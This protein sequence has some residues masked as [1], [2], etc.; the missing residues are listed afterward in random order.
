MSV[1]PDAWEEAQDPATGRT[2]FWRRSTGETTWQR[3]D[4]TPM[5]KGDMQLPTMGH[6]GAPPLSRVAHAVPVQQ[7]M[8]ARPVTFPTGIPAMG[9]P[10]LRPHD[11]NSDICDCCENSFCDGCF[12]CCCS[13][14]RAGDVAILMS[15]TDTPC[16]CTGNYPGACFAHAALGQLTSLTVAAGTALAFRSM[17]IFAPQVFFPV[18]VTCPMR[19][20]VRAKYAIPGWCCSDFWMSYFCEP[21]VLHQVWR[22]LRERDIVQRYSASSNIPMPAG[23]WVQ[24]VRDVV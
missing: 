13:P 12:S 15:R 23:Q 1:S 9:R 10:E 7:V 20:A 18:F 4:A 22:E 6:S 16:F 21:C 8:V 14:C 19:R 3:P 11:W 5:G 2:Y 24:P 17:W